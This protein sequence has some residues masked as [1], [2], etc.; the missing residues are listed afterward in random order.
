LAEL[1]K[2]WEGHFLLVTQNVDD[3]HERAGSMKLMHMHGELKKIRCLNTD[4]VYDWDND[5]SPR[6]P[7][8]CCQT[9]GTLRPHIVWFGE[10]P[11]HMDEIYRALYEA[12]IFLSIGTSGTVYPAAGF[13]QQALMNPRHCH[14]VEINLEPSAGKS[15]F[16][17]TH[18]GSA[19]DI[20]PLYIKQLLENK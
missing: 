13:V 6:Q 7:C 14:T 16:A 18:Y 1:E 12:D 10:M 4:M 11:F 5:V 3:L 9:K 8:T 15:Y 20:L 17:E 19:G 2:H